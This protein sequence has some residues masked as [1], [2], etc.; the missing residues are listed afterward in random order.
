MSGCNIQG[1]WII[2]CDTTLSSVNST[3][4]YTTNSPPTIVMDNEGVLNTTGV[5]QT[6]TNATGTM[7]LP[8]VT[9]TSAGTA[10]AISPSTTGTITIPNLPNCFLKT[11]SYGTVI[12]GEPPTSYTY[13]Q[14]PKP[15]VKTAPPPSHESGGAV[16]A[17]LLV[18]VMLGLVVAYR[19]ANMITRNGN[20]IKI[21]LKFTKKQILT[22]GIIGYVFI[23]CL[24]YGSMSAVFTHEYNDCLKEN[25]ASSS[26]KILCKDSPDPVGAFLAS[27]ISGIAWPL[28]WPMHIATKLFE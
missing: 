15:E 2:E 18:V 16:T 14:A 4:T 19:R 25:S 20:T 11:D 26:A 21:D 24:T 1:N 6:I 7:L 3:G 17:W 28:Y 13:I 23:F 27:V 9:T 5:W 8:G 22:G 12:C 10:I